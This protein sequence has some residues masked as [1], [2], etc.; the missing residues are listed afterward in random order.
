MKRCVK[1]E[2]KVTTFSLLMH[3]QLQAAIF[4]TP[5]KRVSNPLWV[6]DSMDPYGC[7][8]VWIPEKKKFLPESNSSLS[9]VIQID[10]YISCKCSFLFS[11]L[12]V[13][14]TAFLDLFQSPGVTVSFKQRVNVCLRPLIKWRKLPIDDQYYCSIFLLWIS[15][16]QY[17]ST[18]TNP[19]Y[20]TVF[21]FAGGSVQ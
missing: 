9:I 18:L 17:L 6:S 20:C 14:A 4:W 11:Q 2:V 19:H 15:I 13:L 5:G 8:T 21:C 3:C 12:H 16:V 10:N 7:Q 1:L